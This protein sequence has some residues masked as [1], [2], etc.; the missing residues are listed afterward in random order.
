MIYGN[1]APILP[2]S[3][4][5]PSASLTKCLHSKERRRLNV[6]STT[7][8][9]A[10]YLWRSG[11]PRRFVS[12]SAGS[13]PCTYRATGRPGRGHEGSALPVAGRAQSPHGSRTVTYCATD[14][15]SPW[16]Y[17]GRSWNRRTQLDWETVAKSD[18]C[19]CYDR[20]PIYML[21][22]RLLRSCE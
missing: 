12:S 21:C 14:G 1:S 2:D 13:R 3:L 19:R 9:P 7:L 22:N 20:D 16:R 11:W 5:D 10:T 8:I 17:G 18:R 4:P 6:P 15:P